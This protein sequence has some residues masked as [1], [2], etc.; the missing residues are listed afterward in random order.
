MMEQEAISVLDALTAAGYEAYLVGGCVRDAVMNRS[1]H[2][3]DI[4]T[5]ALP[6]EVLRLFPHTAPIGLKHGTVTVVMRHGAYEVTTFRT[7]S[8][9]EQYRRPKTVAFVT[10]LKEDLRRRD[11]TINAMAMDRERNVIDPFD[12]RGDLARGLLRCVGDPAERFR[13]DALRLLRGVRFAAAYGLAIEPATWRALQEQAPLLRHIA[14][15]RIG[16]ELM[17]IVCGDDPAR[18]LELLAASGLLAHTKVP[19]PPALAGTEPERLPAGLRRFG[20]L[21]APAQRWAQ[22]LLALGAGAADARE[23]MLALVYPHAF[24]AEVTALLAW[25]ERLCERLA[26][27]EDVRRAWQL[28]ALDYGAA[29]LRGWLP[30]ARLQL[31]GEAS[32]QEGALARLL[33][34][35]EAWLAAIPA[36]QPRELAVSGADVAAR[37]GRAPGP[38]LGALLRQLLEL[39][40]TGEAVNERSA[41]LAAAERE[42]KRF[43]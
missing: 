11:F 9:Y 16:A 29:A 6:D 18:G 38:W 28:G 31:R 4:A 24:A 13:E 21:E 17:R 30:L 32:Q 20:A 43:G 22:L 40:A 41:L 39:T 10:E 42:A 5:S 1:I 15:E 8:D 14:M 3:F 26:A 37:V 2:D 35:G 34:E 19:L 12:G 36:L 25:D 23:A 27:G 33:A 7:E